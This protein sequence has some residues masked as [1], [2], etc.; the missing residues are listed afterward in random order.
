M[1]KGRAAVAEG[2]DMNALF[3]V[4]SEN[5]RADKKLTAAN[6]RGFESAQTFGAMVGLMGVV[7]SALFGSLFT[8]VSW[9]SANED[10]RRSLSTLGTTLLFLTI[11]LLLLGGY[12]LDLLEKDMPH[13]CSKV[14]RIN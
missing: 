7:L 13:R 14:L 10:A 12:C 11:P 3:L 8:L 4:R 6:S 1:A 9:F 5:A 2:E